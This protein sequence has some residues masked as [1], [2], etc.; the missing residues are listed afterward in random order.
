[1]E[2]F[3]DGGLRGPPLVICRSSKPLQFQLA[4]TWRHRNRRHHRLG[5]R[6]RPAAHVRRANQ[7]GLPEIGSERLRMSLVIPPPT[8]FAGESHHIYDHCRASA[9]C[10][11]C[12]G[13]GSQ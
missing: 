1:M 7:A 13:G 2:G 6:W 8:W 12:R 9:L 4:R 3:T 10:T 5:L 11:T